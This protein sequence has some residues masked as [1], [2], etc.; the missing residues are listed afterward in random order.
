MLIK[1]EAERHQRALKAIEAKQE[2]LVQLYYDDRVTTDVF[3]REQDKLKEE[4]RAAKRLQDTAVAELEDIQQ[5]L[6]L[7]LSRVS[8]PHEVYRDG[9]E[10]ERRI[11]NRAIFERIEVGP[12]GEI[13]GTTLTP[14]YAALSAWQ[15]GLGHPAT[16]PSEGGKCL[17]K[18]NFQPATAPAH[19]TTIFG[20]FLAWLNHKLV[21]DRTP[22]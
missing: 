2:K 19:W 21:S 18:A 8:N 15:P 6:D 12:D 5:A 1:R 17:S 14:V 11:L 20:S 10:L 22:V 13:T 9:T 16:Y 4:R 7:A 3:D